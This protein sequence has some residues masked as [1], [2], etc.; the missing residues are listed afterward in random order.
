MVPCVTRY[1]TGHLSPCHGK[2]SWRRYLGRQPHTGIS[3]TLHPFP[4]SINHLQPW[5]AQ[6][7]KRYINV[8]FLVVQTL[9]IQHRNFPRSPRPIHL[10]RPPLA[11]RM[12]RAKSERTNSSDVRSR[13]GQVPALAGVFPLRVQR[14]VIRFVWRTQLETCAGSDVLLC[15]PYA[16]KCKDCKQS[17]TQ[18]QAKYCHS[19]ST[20]PDP[21]WSLINVAL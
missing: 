16:G 7:V 19:T 1:A 14:I 6:S 18:N 4:V 20:S 11:S 8:T 10:N 3:F 9:L 2:P 15:Q 13:Q 5:S 12:A 17:V 21:F